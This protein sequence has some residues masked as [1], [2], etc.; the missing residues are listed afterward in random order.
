MNIVLSG[1]LIERLFAAVILAFLAST[2]VADDESIVYQNE[3]LGCHVGSTSSSD[4]AGPP[5][6][7]LSYKYILRQLKAFQHDWRG[8]GHLAARTMSDA[9]ANYSDKELKEISHWASNIQ[10]EKHFDYSLGE[11]SDGYQLYG[12]K[13][14]GCHDSVIGRYMTDSPKISCL[15]TEYIIRQ[16]HFFDEGFRNFDQPTKHQLKMQTVV[17]SLTDDEFEALTRFIANASLD[18]YENLDD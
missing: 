6:G 12:D 15:D 3:C 10:G 8:A 16:L 4:V 9:I 11:D 13:C 14:K 2:V 18:K 17:K 5:L 1:G 7:G